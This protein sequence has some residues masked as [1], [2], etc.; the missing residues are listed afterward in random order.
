MHSKSCRLPFASLYFGSSRCSSNRCLLSI[1]PAIALAAVAVLTGSV[2]Y[3]GWADK[4]VSAG[5][6]DSETGKQKCSQE[7]SASL[8][9]CRKD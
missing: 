8:A 7:A 5:Q 1:D 2:F 9:F 6:R 3:R 4:Q